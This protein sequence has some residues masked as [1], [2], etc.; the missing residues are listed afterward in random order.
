MASRWT[1][2]QAAGSPCHE[3]L[4]RV[5]LM[6]AARLIFLNVPFAIVGGV[7]ALWGRDISF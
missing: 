1:R 2:R 5:S 3:E 6:R 4:P 7:F